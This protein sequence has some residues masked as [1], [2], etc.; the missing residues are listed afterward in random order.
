MNTVEL[1]MRDG[2]PYAIDFT[3]PA[4]DADLASVGPR[5]SPGSSRTWPQPLVERVRN[6]R[7]I[8]LTGSWPAHVA[9]R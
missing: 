5:T 8:E 3:N 4:P 6:P 7:P 2:I 1:A 9:G